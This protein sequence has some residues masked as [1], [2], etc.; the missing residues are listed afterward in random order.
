MALPW[1]HSTPTLPRPVP[2]ASR[3][4]A[5]AGVTGLADRAGTAARRSP[6]L[7]RL[8]AFATNPLTALVVMLVGLALLFVLPLVGLPFVAVVVLPAVI[9]HL[10]PEHRTALRRPRG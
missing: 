10:R 9:Y 3:P 4:T 8:G 5:R 6:R 7:A 1:P 2:A